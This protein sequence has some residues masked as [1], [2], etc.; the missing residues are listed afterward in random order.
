[1]FEE[2]SG[3][4]EKLRKAVR[5]GV[6]ASQSHH[7]DNLQSHS[8]I[9]VPSP[10]ATNRSYQSYD[11]SSDISSGLPSPNA[12]SQTNNRPVSSL[13]ESSKH[14]HPSPSS[15]HYLEISDHS[16][17]TI[18][19]SPTQD[20]S[21]SALPTASQALLRKPDGKGTSSQTAS[22]PMSLFMVCFSIV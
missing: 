11:L 10:I 1:M 20:L 12:N 16:S 22:C 5:I 19:Q 2:V 9:S 17:C 13:D 7:S 18:L 8:N 4:Y 14:S 6:K 21:T 15:G 3:G